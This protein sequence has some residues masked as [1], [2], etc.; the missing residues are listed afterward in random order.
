MMTKE[1]DKTVVISEATEKEI[2]N[3]LNKL[4]KELDSECE[5]QGCKTP[6]NE[7]CQITG[8]RFYPKQVNK[9]SDKMMD[10]LDE[11][12]ASKIYDGFDDGHFNSMKSAFVEGYVNG[13][14][15]C[16][17]EIYALTKENRR[18][19]NGIFED[20]KTILNDIKQIK[21]LEQKVMDLKS[22]LTN[23]NNMIYIYNKYVED[24][25]PIKIQKQM[26]KEI[27]SH[28][29]KEVKK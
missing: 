15:R 27:E 12:D 20:G 16:K 11:S 18:L 14:Y 9:E 8:C 19:Q 1:P 24:F 21:E 28:K 29:F 26:C 13:Q 17:S 22:E 6:P 23:R 4:Y 5:K 25:V 10:E 7:M 3:G 2:A